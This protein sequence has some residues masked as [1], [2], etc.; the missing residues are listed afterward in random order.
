M[1]KDAVKVMRSS[2]SQLRLLILDEV[3]MLLNLN[4]AYVYLRLDEIFVRDKW[5]GGINVL[6]VV[7][8]YNYH[9]LMEHQCFTESPTNL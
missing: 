2:L 9:L 1:G 8:F 6:F 3:S 5:F 4:L 7:T